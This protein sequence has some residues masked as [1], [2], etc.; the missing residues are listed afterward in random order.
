L[1]PFAHGRIILLAFI[2]A[3]PTA[4]FGYTDWQHFYDEDWLFPIEVRLFLSGGRIVLL[5]IGVIFRRKAEK[6]TKGSLTMASMGNPIRHLL[7][8]DR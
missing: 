8:K 2:F 1:P 6:E 3:F 7:R 5:S 4:L